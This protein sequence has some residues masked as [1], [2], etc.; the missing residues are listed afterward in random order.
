MVGT[1]GR[2]GLFLA[3]LAAA[4][5]GTSGVFASALIDAGWSPA[6]A[7]TARLVVA[8]LALTVPALVSLRGRWGLLRQG[9]GA[10]LA[11][12]LVAVAGCQ[13]FYFNAVERLD[14]GVALLL[15]YL[16]SVLVVGWL[17][18]RLGHTPRRLT[19]VG[20]ALAMLGLAGVLDITGSVR[21][22]LVGVFW[23]LSAAVGL[24]VFFVLSAS[25]HNR[26]PPVVMAWAGMCIGAVALL[27]AGGLGVVPMRAS[28]GPVSFLGNEMSWLVP[29]LGLSLVAAAL[30]YVAGIGA[31]RLLGPKI[32]S[33]VGLTE[34]LFAV[35]FAWLLLGQQLAAIQIAGGMVVVAGI[36]LV[37]LDQ[38]ASDDVEPVAVTA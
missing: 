33:F 3:L 37:K 11:Y 32:S 14:V 15:E 5:F 28:T 24:A 8:S 22:D 1:S 6:A 27:V 4:C 36:V 35:L 10:T 29:V 30:A 23:G 13:L 19:V 20:S 16:G 21:I 17:W 25:E 38:V 26:L 31:A 2:S 34:V 7:V 9:A 12:G 18:L